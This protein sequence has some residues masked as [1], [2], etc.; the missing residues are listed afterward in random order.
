MTYRY[1]NQTFGLPYANPLQASSSSATSALG[2]LITKG[3][4]LGQGLHGNTPSGTSA[5]FSVDIGLLHITA[6]STQK[7]TGTELAWLVRDLAAADKN[8]EAVPWIIVTS[9]YP[10]HLSAME[11]QSDAS[12]LGWHSAAGEIC[13]DGICNGTEFMSCQQAGEPEG[14]K[15]VGEMV[16]ESSEATQNLFNRYGVDIYNAGHSHQYAVTW[17]MLAGA[18]TQFNYSNPQGTVFITEGNGGVPKTGPNTTIG[19]APPTPSWGRSHGTGGA[20]GE[21]ATGVFPDPS[22]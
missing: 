5:Y 4:Y 15:T 8:R 20:Y 18:A 6:L 13:L 11:T 21:R 16:D 1:L 19:K 17:P 12:A 2:H 7:P 14:C 3:S 22:L 10:I 9:H